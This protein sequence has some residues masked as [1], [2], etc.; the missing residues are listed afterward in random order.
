MEQLPLGAWILVDSGFGDSHCLSQADSLRS[1]HNAFI[2]H[3]DF[4]GSDR[5]QWTG[6]TNGFTP[7]FWLEPWSTEELITGYVFF[8]L[9]SDYVCVR[10]SCGLETTCQ[11]FL[12]TTYVSPSLLAFSGFLSS[13]LFPRTRCQWTRNPKIPESLAL[14]LLF[15]TASQYCSVLY[16]TIKRLTVRHVKSSPVVQSTVSS[17]D[18][19]AHDQQNRECSEQYLAQL[20]LCWT[21]NSRDF[22]ASSLHP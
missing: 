1:Y 22:H 16:P 2:L 17:I 11:G 13:P 15:H 9:S 19:R 6:R 18:R 4:P 21:L 20:R 3:A 10:T 5:T 8:F 14:R 12:H 7:T